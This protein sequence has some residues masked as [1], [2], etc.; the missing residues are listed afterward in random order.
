MGWIKDIVEPKKR[1]WEDYYKNRWQHDKVVRSTHGVNCTGSC[2]WNIFVKDGI[3]TWETQALDHPRIDDNL[4]PYE[5]RGC[6]RG[7]SFS[8]YIYS[9]IRVKYPYMRGVLI[10][11]WREA[12]KQFPDP[13]Q[14]WA[15]IQ[16]NPET[17]SSYHSARGKGGF[18]R[19]HWDEVNEL[20]AAS[21]IY[22]IKKHGPDRIVGFS[23]IPA[24]SMISYAGGSRFLQLMGGLCL[25]FYDWYCDLPNAS[26]EMWG[27]Q[28]DVAESADWYNS[29]YIAVVGSNLSMTRTPDVH[30]ATEARHNG[31]K[32][33][34][35]SPDF[36]QVSK[37]SDWWI[38]LHQGQDGAFWMAVNH[39]ILK[40]FYADKKTEY[41]NAYL[42]KY[43]D[44]PYL[45]LL[46]EKEGVHSA[47]KFLNLK[48]LGKDL[49]HG[50]FRYLVIDEK[51]GEMKCPQGSIGDRWSKEKGKW[52]L[53]SKDSLDGSEI[54]PLLS[55][56]DNSDDS[57][58]LEV[59]DFS[60]ETTVKRSVPSKKIKVGEKSYT[61]T[62]VFD[63][64]MAQFGVDR[65]LSGDYA[66]DYDDKE[67]AYTP[68][69][70]EAH[71][72]IGRE[73]LI[74]FAKEWAKTAEL[75]EGK[76]S[77][78]IGA[79]ANHWYHSNLIY[80]A[81][82]TALILT[83]CVGKNGGGLQHY[84]GQEKLAPAAPWGSI[85]FAKDWN[86]SAR[87]QNAPSWHYMNSGQWRHE[88]EYQEYQALPKD[89]KLGKGHVA[90]MNVRA[91]KS[92]WLPFYPQYSESNFDIVKNAQESG[93]TTDEEIKSY[94]V[95]QLKDDK[96]KYS[97][98]DPDA[99]ENWPRVWYIW[100]G[101]ALMSSA[102]GHEYFLKH[103]LGTH[104]NC[105]SEEKAE[106]F[107]NE[108]KWHEDCPKG[109][110]DLIIDI[111]FRMDTSALY[112][113]IILPAAT[114]YEKTDLNSTDMHSFIN[115]LSEAVPPLWESKSDWDIFK[116]L[117]KKVSELAVD[118]IPDPLKEVVNVPLLHDTPDELAQPEM[119]YWAAGEC[120][121]IP[122][123]TMH[124]IVFAERDYVNLYNRFISLGPRA[125]DV[126]L[127]AHGVSYSVTDFYDEMI[128]NNH[129]PTET[130]NQKT[131]PSLSE[132]E[133]VCDV[134]LNL[135]SETNG[136]LAHRAYQSL[137][138]QV[139]RSLSK[140]ADGSRDVRMNHK[141]IVS[142]PRRLLNSPI[143]SGLMT[144]GRAY[145]GFCLNVDHLVPWRT[146]TGRQSLYLDHEGYIAFGE[147]L[148]TYKPS[149]LPESFGDL[150]KTER[151]KNSIRLNF[152]TPH[153]K[154]S[155]HSTY[156]ETERMLTLSRGIEPFW[157]HPD[158]AEKIG[159]VDNDWVEVFNDHGVVCTRA[160]V[161]H[162]IPTGAGFI[163]HSPE[164][165]HSVPK[166]PIRNDR[167]AGGHN[168]LT[169][170]RLKPNLMVGGYGQYTY[171]FNYWGPVGNNRD[172]H[173]FVRKLTKL[174]W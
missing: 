78:I 120:E 144:N 102:K 40:E 143:W 41:F 11:L 114:W 10:D 27:E 134:I 51:S 174:K 149:P 137:E 20:I 97:I 115:P 63:L 169:R 79:G 90:D 57:V 46:E 65:G 150:D 164:R 89:S 145:N 48:M 151:E 28:T 87:L 77:I 44:M 5:P 117:A 55:L 1:S 129:T 98:E 42:K 3:I 161:S 64:L 34:V 160:C 166:S 93:C 73:T 47:G 138:K 2:S 23:P 136:E 85:A 8:W 49:E 153:G 108:V 152:L 107:V 39:V 96:L 6:Q 38:P 124:K 157:M 21:N 68:A 59:Q 122:G 54:D 106:E 86:A 76:C 15:H 139:G 147:N 118:H 14:A 135:A 128:N 70:Q 116:D 110:L 66:K 131:Y 170:I 100:R 62:T 105:I 53:E 94:V 81:G 148:P 123:K 22:T 172:T 95:D 17:R 33:V 50:E 75:T 132:A 142:Q 92:G 112:S 125:R 45:V 74:R 9:P 104:H 36:S 162:R 173:I 109:K 58:Y 121:P 60:G 154:W 159:V 7:M 18:R 19:V 111:N 91:V 31:T 12:K 88:R 69:W 56:L 155:I 37:I 140:L 80:R 146:I 52:N 72:G 13:V 43:S 113:D 16:E 141:D 163:Y 4:P 67:A 99:P 171:A 32:L 103:Y 24:M 84:V 168:S 156:G 119:K 101:N 30:F 26:P 29:K 158:D 130:W 167:R 133:D 25:S 82:I 61:V 71:T 83:G 127:D 126:G 165:T 35:L